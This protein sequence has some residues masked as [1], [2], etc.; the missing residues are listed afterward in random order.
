[1]S[2][3]AK[4]PLQEENNRLKSTS[5]QLRARENTRKYSLSSV[6]RF[7]SPAGRGKT[8]LKIRPKISLEEWQ[9][10]Q[11]SMSPV[12]IIN[13]LAPLIPSEC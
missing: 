1:M 12:L 11:P 10:A 2:L 9:N 8:G 6:K 7:S 3:T 13:N 4:E 5:Y